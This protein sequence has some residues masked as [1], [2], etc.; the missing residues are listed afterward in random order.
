M[1]DSLIKFEV[2]VYDM[3]KKKREYF[4]FKKKRN[5]TMYRINTQKVANTCILSASYIHI[6]ANNYSITFVISDHLY[7]ILLIT[8]L[9]I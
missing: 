8:Y 3:C 2:H 7:F 6:S 1:I 4:I 5:K 9:V